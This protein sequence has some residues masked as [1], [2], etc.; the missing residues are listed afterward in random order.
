MFFPFQCHQL[1][2]RGEWGLTCDDEGLAIG[3]IVLVKR[4]QSSEAVYAI[5]PLAKLNRI[6]KAIYGDHAVSCHRWFCERV[7]AIADA[8]SRE[9]YA[10]ACISAVQLRLGAFSPE[11]MVCLRDVALSLQKFNP[12][13]PDEP[14]DG[15]GRWT[16]DAAN[17]I[18]PVIAPF[19]PECLAA[20]E[21]AKRICIGQYTAMGRYTG[22]AWLILCIRSHVPLECGY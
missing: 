9:Q 20:I 5:L 1:V 15:H 8:M 19:T 11:A 14:R 21:A 2:P 16:T 12:N 7:Q 13:W 17:P 22:H 6:A 4:V 18:V 10:L 3:P